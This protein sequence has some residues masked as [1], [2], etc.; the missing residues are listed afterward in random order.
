MTRL[1]VRRQS[2]QFR[3]RVVRDSGDVRQQ[4]SGNDYLS[5]SRHPK[6]IAAACAALERWGAGSSGSPL[7]SGYTQLHQQ[8][9]EALKDWLAVDGVILF[10]SGFAANHGVITTL[11]ADGTIFFDRLC[12]AS[13]IDG[14]RA[15]RNRFKRFSHNAV[16]DINAAPNDWVITE[17]TFSM[18]GDRVPGVDLTD[19][20]TE[21]QL[22]LLLDDAHGLGVWGEQGLGSFAQVRDCARVTI[23]TFGKAFGA[24][25]AF[26]AGNH[27]DIESLI[28]FCR[29]YIY[30][31][32]LPPAQVAAAHAALQII[33]SSQGTELRQ[34]LKYNIDYFKAQFEQRGLP[35]INSDSPV[36][37]WIVGDDA[38]V[39]QIAAELRQQSLFVSAVRPPTVAKGSA[40]IRFSLQ[41]QHTKADIDQL[42]A[43]LDR[44]I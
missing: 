1:E 40:R 32:S 38:T 18:D 8:L 37:S 27:D 21:K 39:M 26:V 43:S 24:G 44:L 9:E 28:Q 36:Q 19:M 33:R 10:N 11:I 20:V 15:T 14:I 42:L 4:F 5:L 23:G 16:A 12:H 25:G 35:L 29:E 41:S 17:G 22:N 34:Q 6:V 7:L 2:A 3:R 30:S 13:L 31:T